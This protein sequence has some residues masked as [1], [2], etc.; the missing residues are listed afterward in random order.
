MELT[1]A[2]QDPGAKSTERPKDF[3]GEGEKDIVIKLF[4]KK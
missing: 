3:K 2:I 1:V 4:R